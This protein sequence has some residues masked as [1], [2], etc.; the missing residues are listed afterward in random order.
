MRPTSLINAVH[1]AHLDSLYQRVASHLRTSDRYPRYLDSVYELSD[2]DRTV[3]FQSES[4]LPTHDDV[5]PRILLL[6][7]NA[8]PKSIQNGMFHTAESG[9]AA[10]WKDLRAIGAL[11]LQDDVLRDAS[12]LRSACVNGAYS[13]RFILGFVCC[14]TFP[15][16]RPDELK[17]LFGPGREP[18]GFKDTQDRLNRTLQTWCPQAIVSF[19]G[20][21]F[22]TITRISTKG[23]TKQLRDHLLWAPHQ[24]GTW[25]GRLFQTYPAGWWRDPSARRDSLQRVF[26]AIAHPDA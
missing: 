9:V 16:L 8:H 24:A 2:V 21:V 17:E 12:L 1:I 22:Q 14:W 20:D 10:L 11:L 6:F 3:T 26:E 7:S 23:Y 5:R 18:P 19:N 4:I 25:T 13:G 15:T